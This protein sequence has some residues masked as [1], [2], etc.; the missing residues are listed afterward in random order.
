MSINQS[1][2]LDCGERGWTRDWYR[3][4]PS[5]GSSPAITSA[6]L[7]RGVNVGPGVVGTGCGV[8]DGGNGDGGSGEGKGAG[9]GGEMIIGGKVGCLCGVGCTAGLGVGPLVETCRI[10]DG[11]G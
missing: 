8:G 5:S 2:A 3:P 4:N 6:N 10:G 11:V 1:N 9:V 7:E